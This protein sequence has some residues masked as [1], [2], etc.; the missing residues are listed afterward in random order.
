MKLFSHALI[1]TEA[2]HGEALENLVSDIER[3]KKDSIAKL[4]E[5]N[6]SS[7]RGEK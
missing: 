3:Q 7:Q 2:G 1:A 5:P 4:E 6:T